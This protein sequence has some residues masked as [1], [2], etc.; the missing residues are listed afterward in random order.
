MIPE[1]KGGG[2]RKGGGGQGGGGRGWWRRPAVVELRAL[3]TMAA[4]QARLATLREG[5]RGG[6]RWEVARRRI[7]DGRWNMEG[8]LAPDD[9]E[10]EQNWFWRQA[11]QK[12]KPLVVEVHF[13][14]GIKI[15][16]EAFRTYMGGRAEVGQDAGGEYNILKDDIILVGDETVH[17]CL[18]VTFVR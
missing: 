16:I 12:K 8:P 5:T 17:K 13:L 7:A 14:D 9:E 3:H 10:V 15:C 4:R 18:S 2:A 1:L 11:A 6:R